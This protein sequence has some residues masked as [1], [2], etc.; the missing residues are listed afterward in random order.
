VVSLSLKEGNS[1][2]SCVLPDELIKKLD[3]LSK[4]EYMLRSQYIRKVLIDHIK[5]KFAE[6]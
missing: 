4:S 6:E 2:V 5:N 3:E 1:Q